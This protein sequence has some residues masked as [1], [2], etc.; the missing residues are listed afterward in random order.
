VNVNPIVKLVHAE[1]VL[2]A[3]VGDADVLPVNEREAPTA[4]NELIKPNWLLLSDILYQPGCS[5]QK[6]L[7]LC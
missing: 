5:F 3:E 1:D 4:E 7:E 6:A 2:L